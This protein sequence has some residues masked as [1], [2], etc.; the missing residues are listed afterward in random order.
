MRSRSSLYCGT[1]GNNYSNVSSINFIFLLV[2]IFL[3]L[4]IYLLFINKLS[5]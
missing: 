5:M 2:G 4:L 1:Y 3:I